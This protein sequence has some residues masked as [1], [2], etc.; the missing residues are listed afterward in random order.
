M[1]TTSNVPR[2]VEMYDSSRVDMLGSS[3]L[4]GCSLGG[5]VFSV[6]GVGTGFSRGSV[7]ILGTIVPY[8][9]SAFP[10]GVSAKLVSS[11]R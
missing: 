3:R 1:R 5:E 9:T 8:R 10:D 4:Y 7:S 11:Y 2:L 6:G